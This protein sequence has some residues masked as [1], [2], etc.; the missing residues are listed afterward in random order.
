MLHST[1]TARPLRGKRILVTRTREQASSFSGRLRKLGA[2]PFEFPVIRIAPPLDWQ[3][4]DDAL[5]HLCGATFTYYDWLIFTSVNGVESVF[6]RLNEFGLSLPVA[7]ATRVAAIGPA[8]AAALA[9]YGVQTD[10]MPDEYIAEGVAA[11]LI[12][13]ARQ[14]GTSL[15]GKRILLPRAAVARDVLITQLKAAGATVQEVAAYRM[16]PVSSDDAQ[17]LEVVRML[18]AGELHMLTFTSSSTV[19]NFMH[20]LTSSAPALAE[21]LRDNAA[22]EP[23]P[24]IAC[25]GPITAQTARE[26]GL[27]PQ[28]E[29]TTFTIDG[30]IEAIVQ[31]EGIV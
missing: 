20:W 28:I 25:I 27:H 9:R 17:G 24:I 23:L 12:E 2:A 7:S 3:P 26:M 29:A 5:R 13:D 8:T 22:G 11:A 18:Q 21:K 4:L 16:L 30:L 6:E 31:H 15:V 14:R 19:R 1:N 10:L